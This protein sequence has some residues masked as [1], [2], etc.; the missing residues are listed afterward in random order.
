MKF[1]FVRV[2]VLTIIFF[3]AFTFS[4]SVSAQQKSTSIEGYWSG[5]GYQLYLQQGMF[6]F[7]TEGNTAISGVYHLENGYLLLGDSQQPLVYKV[8]RKG[9]TLELLG[10]ETEIHLQADKHT[11]H[12]NIFMGT[13]SQIGRENAQSEASSQLPEHYFN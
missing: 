8:E 4:L 12:R 2:F 6:L 11:V 7:Q 1:T 9:N 10:A 5:Q 3:V 13:I